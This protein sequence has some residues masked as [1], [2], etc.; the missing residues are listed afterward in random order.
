MMVECIGAVAIVG[1]GATVLWLMLSEERR[2]AKRWCRERGLRVGVF[3][4]GE[5][6]SDFWYVGI[7]GKG[8]R[9]MVP[10]GGGESVCVR[11]DED[12]GIEFYE[13]EGTK[14]FV[15]TWGIVIGIAKVVLAEV[16]KR[17]IVRLAEILLERLKEEWG[18]RGVATADRVREIAE[19]MRNGR[20]GVE[21]VEGKDFEMAEKV[22]EAIVSEARGKGIGGVEGMSGE[23][24]F[25]TFLSSV[26]GVE[27]K[28]GV[29]S[30][31]SSKGEESGEEP[32][33]EIRNEPSTKG[34][35]IESVRVEERECGEVRVATIRAEP[36][37]EWDKGCGIERSK[38]VVY[39]GCTEGDC[40][41]G[42]EEQ[43]RRKGADGEA[44]EK[45]GKSEKAGKVEDF[46]D[47]YE[48]RGW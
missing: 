42:R 32:K 28:V 21:D 30:E 23:E 44:R 26:E 18:V 19:E 31:E 3:E 13:P 16:A 27:R 22:V 11:E 14:R 41:E 46:V 12:G 4:F 29:G 45:E 34:G 40:E 7:D 10:N 47:G 37:V 36:M 48:E 5:G 38:T 24:A 1:F 8:N 25:E 9:W 2:R 35:R 6:R 43:E 33:V 17:A 20:R 39:R 15:L